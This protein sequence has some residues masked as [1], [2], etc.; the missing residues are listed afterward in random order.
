MGFADETGV[1]AGHGST[2]NLPLAFGCDDA[3]YLATLEQAIHAI[4]RWGATALVISAGFDTYAGDPLGGFQLS[5]SCYQRIGARCAAMGIPIVVIQE[6][7]Y[8]V[9]ALGD[10]VVALLNGIEA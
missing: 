1:G 5:R 7:G 4:T 6:G 8:A 2:L 10:N 9:S 3:T